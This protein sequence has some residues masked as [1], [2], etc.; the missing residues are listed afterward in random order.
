[1]RSGFKTGAYKYILKEF[2]MKRN[3]VTAIIG[4]ALAGALLAACAGS[5]PAQGSQSAAAAAPTQPAASGS[6]GGESVAIDWRGRS[7][8]VAIPDW[9][10][11]AIVSDPDNKISDLPRLKGKISILREYT[12]KDLD[13]VQAFGNSQIMGDTATR[14]KASVRAAAADAVTGNTDETRNV[15]DQF[16][17]IFANQEISGL[18][19]ELDFWIKNRKANGEEE[20]SYYLVYGIAEEN[21]NYLVEQALGKVQAK[22]D[23][24]R[25]TVDILRNHIKELQIKVVGE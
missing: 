2:E 9:V 21:F 17:A 13:G 20:Y 4:I 15:V 23:A 25:E 22:T 14:I 11:L 5:P 24:E 10:K 6:Q 1:M 19:Q 12:G 16:N 7:I 3:V 8:D 18:G